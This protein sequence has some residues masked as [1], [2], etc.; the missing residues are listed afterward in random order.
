MY[1]RTYRGG[2]SIW[3]VVFRESLH[4][5]VCEYGNNLNRCVFV[6]ECGSRPRMPSCSTSCGPTP[7]FTYICDELK[8]VTNSYRIH[9]FIYITNPWI[10]WTH[11]WPHVGRPPGSHTYVTNLNTSRT[12]IESTNSYISRTHEFCE[13]I[14][15]LMWANPQVHIYMSRT[16]I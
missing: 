13:L 3:I 7:R 16:K 4:V 14:H 9:E 10:L 15:D 6:R 11:T 1:N 8:H 5:L 2:A 12:H